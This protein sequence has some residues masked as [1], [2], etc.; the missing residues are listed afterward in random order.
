MSYNG[1][2]YALDVRTLAQDF[3][4]VQVDRGLAYS[5]SLTLS[6][7][8]YLLTSDAMTKPDAKLGAGSEFTFF[9]EY[10]SFCFSKW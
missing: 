10:F 6:H 1:V 3:G 5:C 4:N 8:N 2:Y 9:S 7:L